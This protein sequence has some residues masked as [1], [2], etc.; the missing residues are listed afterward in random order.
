MAAIINPWSISLAIILGS[1]YFFFCYRSKQKPDM[2]EFMA[3]VGGA[4]G[5]STALTLIAIGAYFPEMQ[6]KLDPATINGYM[7]VAGFALAYLAGETIYKHLA[8]K[9]TRAPV[10]DDL[11]DEAR[12]PG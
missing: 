9:Y 10:Q 8:S 11:E 7:C 2:K 3:I 12:E 1:L 4:L 6:R 5:I